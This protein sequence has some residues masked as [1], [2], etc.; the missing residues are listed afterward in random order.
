MIDKFIHIVKGTTPT[1]KFVLRHVDPA[2]IAAAYLDITDATQTLSKDFT[3]MET[4]T[5][6]IAWTLSQTETLALQGD[7]VLQMNFLTA[8]GTRGASRRCKVILE[9][10]ERNAVMEVSN[11]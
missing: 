9:E 3:A 11:E 10:N 5:D 6:F 1:I 7:T 2:D 8:S 4:G